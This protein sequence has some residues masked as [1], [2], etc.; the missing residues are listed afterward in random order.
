MVRSLSRILGFLSQKVGLKLRPQAGAE[1]V[2]DDLLSLRRQIAYEGA[3]KSAIYGQLPKENA[4]Y[5]G[6]E[7]PNNS[8]RKNPYSTVAG[9]SLTLPRTRPVRLLNTFSLYTKLFK[10]EQVVLLRLFESKEGLGFLG[11]DGFF[12]LLGVTASYHLGD[13]KTGKAPEGAAESSS[14]GG[15]DRPDNVLSFVRKV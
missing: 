12:H 7:G 2:S 4:A 13:D 14:K 1:V 6:D 11:D 15:S 9:P 5:H 10:S 8:V 3:S